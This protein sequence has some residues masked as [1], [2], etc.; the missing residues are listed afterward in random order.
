VEFRAEGDYFTAGGPSVY[1][2]AKPGEVTLARLTR[3][4]S[5]THYRMLVAHGQFISF[6]DE[7]DMRIGAIEQDNWPHAFCKLDCDMETFIQA[8]NANHIHG[9]Y[10]NWIEELKV[11]CECAGIEYV[12]V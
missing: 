5:T 9:T 1:H 10:G 2:I 12:R 8:A 4:G 11:F 7:E 6:G 3:S